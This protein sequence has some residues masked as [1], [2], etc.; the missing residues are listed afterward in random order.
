M[1]YSGLLP[2]LRID[3][4]ILEREIEMC[5]CPTAGFFHFYDGINNNIL[6]YANCVNALNRA[7]SISTGLQNIRLER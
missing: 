2:F 3:Y 1:P 6:A 5:Q 4:T 7:S